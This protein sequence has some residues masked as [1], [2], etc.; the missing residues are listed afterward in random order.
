[1]K[2]FSDHS[3][4]E[5]PV[6]ISDTL[7]IFRPT[8]SASKKYRE[9]RTLLLLERTWIRVGDETLGIFQIICKHLY[10]MITKKVIESTLRLQCDLSNIL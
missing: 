3:G 10:C 8:H 7:Q 2:H 6:P 5:V 1:M 4:G 9:K